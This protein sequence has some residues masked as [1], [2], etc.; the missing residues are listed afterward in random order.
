MGSGRKIQKILE[1]EIIAESVGMTFG[2]VPRQA[3]EGFA[4]LFLFDQVGPFH[5]FEDLIVVF[6]LRTTHIAARYSHDLDFE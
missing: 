1:Y 6:T 4:S 5:P 3:F 2:P